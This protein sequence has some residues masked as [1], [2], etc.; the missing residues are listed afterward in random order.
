M[1]PSANVDGITA[2]TVGRY[3]RALPISHLNACRLDVSHWTSLGP[4]LASR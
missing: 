3:H 1:H 2:G 4:R